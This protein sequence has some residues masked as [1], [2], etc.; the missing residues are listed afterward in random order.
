[1]SSVAE[2][3]S[4][5]EEEVNVEGIQVFREARPSP[6]SVHS[7]SSLHINTATLGMSRVVM[8]TCMQIANMICPG[9]CRRAWM[10]LK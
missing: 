7:L 10:N 9:L 6:K 1:M 8:F 4:D 2:C 5:G 3:S